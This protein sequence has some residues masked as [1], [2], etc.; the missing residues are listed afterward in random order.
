[1]VRLQKNSLSNKKKSFHPPHPLLKAQ[2]LKIC[3][4]NT[5]A[6]GNDIEF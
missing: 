1:M 2:D 5:L 4:N 6:H 3:A